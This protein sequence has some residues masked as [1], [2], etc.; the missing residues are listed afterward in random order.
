MNIVEGLRL[1]VEL[2]VAA[3]V[4]T[5]LV[6]LLRGPLRRGFGASIAYAGWGLVPVAMMAVLVPA[7]ATTA[8]N[9][10]LAIGLADA[11]VQSASTQAAGTLDYRLWVAVAWAIGATAMAWRLGRQQRGFR[12][13]LGRLHRRPDGLMQAEVSAGLPAALGLWRPLIVVPADF[14]TR[15]SSRQ[16]RLMR[17]HERVHLARGDLHANAFA[18]LLRCLFWFNPL[19]HH[20]AQRFRHDQELACDLRVIRRHPRS[21]RAYGEAMFKTQLAAQ[22]LPL[23]CHWGHSHP[24]TERIAMLKQPVPTL[25]R[26]IAGTTLVAALSLATGYGAWAAQPASVKTVRLADVTA[27]STRTPPPRYPA[28]A[29][30]Q[31]IGGKV[32]L[33]IDVDAEGRPGH[34]EIE[35]S[36][37][38]GVFDQAVLDVAPQWRFTPQVKDGRPV[39]GRIRVP[40]DFE[41]DPVAPAQAPQPPAKGGLATAI[42]RPPVPPAPPL[43]PTPHAP[44]TS[45]PPPLPAAPPAPPAPPRYPAEAAAQG[46]GGKV[47]LVIDVDEMGNAADVAV[48]SAEPAG[49]FDQAAV[50]AA[51]Q[52]KFNPQLKDGKAVPSRVRVPV[53]FAPDRA[54]AE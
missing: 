17:A 42:P 15:Y 6:L 2:T 5:S 16:R 18:A 22:P 45:P 46:I 44:G 11:V 54:P 38:A 52:W 9:A 53:D 24:L 34:I 29:A 14:D 25:P 39:A 4:A 32:V 48:E 30:A 47:V 7:A 35:R 19:I 49:V 27:P 20:A 23:G 3:A 37:P 51:R 41:P 26:W 43:P 12:R 28:E 10:P 31:G 33:V 50:D 8:T 40:V 21:R 1:L 36:E 13:G